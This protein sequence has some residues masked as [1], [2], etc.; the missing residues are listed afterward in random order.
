VGNVPVRPVI[1]CAGMLRN[2]T[3]VLRHQRQSELSARKKNGLP[4]P[5]VKKHSKVI[6]KIAAKEAIA[7]Q[8]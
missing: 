2:A 7:A 8:Q 5:A 3:H 1:L 6:A 4:A